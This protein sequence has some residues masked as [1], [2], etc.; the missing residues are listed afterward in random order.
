MRTERRRAR[1]DGPGHDDI[2]RVVVV[3]ELPAS[4]TSRLPTYVEEETAAAVDDD[5]DDEQLTLQLLGET[6]AFDRT[7]TEPLPPMEEVL[8]SITPLQPVASVSS[9]CP[10]HPTTCTDISNSMSASA[11]RIVC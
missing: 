8:L 2:D 7:S 4:F 5:D 6:L 3:A 11:C 1:R 10:N 9:D